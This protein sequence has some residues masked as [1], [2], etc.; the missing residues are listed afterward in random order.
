MNTKFLSLLALALIFNT[1]CKEDDPVV[2]PPVENKNV[3]VNLNYDFNF[4]NQDFA[5][6][7]EYTLDNGY[8][9]RYSLATFYLSKPVIMDDAGGMTALSPEYLIV[10]PDVTMSDLGF[11]QEGHAH[12]FNFSIGVDSASNT[13]NGSTGVQPTDFS[14]PNHPL[15]PQPEGMYWSW[16]SGY[17]FVKI[18]GEVDFEGDGTYD[19]VFKYHLGTNEFRKDRSTMVH[20]DVLG[21]E[22]INMLLA[23]DYK[24]FFN[25][26]DLTTEILS[27]SMG[28]GRA[29]G[30]KMMDQFDQAMTIS[31][32]ENGNKNN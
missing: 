19:Q 29:L 22:T 23:I 10:R 26:V 25:G 14:D 6:N 28:E 5:L 31:K 24:A 16:A 17:I 15:G 20:S 7:T 8:K 4:G 1:S 32:M 3:Q 11:I 12:M 13:E 30:I 21:G 18:E 2:T 27:M 9:V